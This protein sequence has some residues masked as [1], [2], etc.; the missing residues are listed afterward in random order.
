[1]GL[2]EIGGEVVE[3]GITVKEGGVPDYTMKFRPEES[4]L[5]S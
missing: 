3:G 2:G 4:L 5:S 1:M